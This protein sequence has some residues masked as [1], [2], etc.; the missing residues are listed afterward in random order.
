M[1]DKIWDWC[2][3]IKGSKGNGIKFEYNDALLKKLRIKALTVVGTQTN[4]NLTEREQP[5]GD[6]NKLSIWRIQKDICIRIVLAEASANC[7]TEIFSI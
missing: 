1:G 6:W 7:G 4:N 5:V 3:P 2:L